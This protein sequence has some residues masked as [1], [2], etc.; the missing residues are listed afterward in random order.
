MKQ[1]I[2]LLIAFQIVLSFSCEKS[3]DQLT[4]N[5]LTETVV[6][7]PTFAQTLD[8]EILAANPL[9]KSPI[10][11]YLRDVDVNLAANT[12]HGYFVTRAN[13]PDPSYRKHEV[14][15]SKTLGV[16]AANPN[17]YI[18]GYDNETAVFRLIRSSTLAA[19][20]TDRMSF[21]STDL[22]SYED[23][24]YVGAYS[25]NYSVKINMRTIGTIVNCVEYPAAEQIVLSHSAEV[26]GCNGKIYTNW[27][28]AFAAGVTSWTLLL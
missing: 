4:V 18:Y 24:I 23:R 6:P 7:T 14:Y 3:E 12:W 27:S 21:R 10:V 20:E 11:E 26:K 13:L 19:A 17:L 1:L 9:E 2:A 28:F 16:L 25:A 15:L 22:K 8:A 5:E